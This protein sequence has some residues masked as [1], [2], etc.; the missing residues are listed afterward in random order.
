MRELKPGVEIILGW[1]W[2][3]GNVV[4][5]STCV[6]DDPIHVTYQC[7]LFLLRRIRQIRIHIQ[8]YASTQTFT[9]IPTATQSEPQTSPQIT[10]LA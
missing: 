2:D 6:V 10:Q 3:D 8:A 5:R 9:Q 7:F 1:E 4:R